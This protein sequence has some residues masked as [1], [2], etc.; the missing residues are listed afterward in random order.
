MKLPNFLVAVLCL[1]SSPAWPECDPVATVFGEVVCLSDISFNEKDKQHLAK[2][3]DPEILKERIKSY[4]IQLLIERIQHIAANKILPKDA[5]EVTEDD[6]QRHIDH[7]EKFRIQ[8]DRNSKEI[9]S[10]IKKLLKTNQYSPRHKEKLENILK[11][12]EGYIQL[13]RKVL[14]GR[15]A[16]NNRMSTEK[17]KLSEIMMEENKIKDHRRMVEQWKMNQALYKQYGGRI[18]IQQA[19]I[20]PIDAY[21]QFLSDIQEKGNLKI[22]KIE[23]DRVI[24]GFEKYINMKHVYSSVDGSKLFDKPHWEKELNNKNHKKYIESLKAIPTLN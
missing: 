1:M 19:E 17:R 20:E 2:N 6:V 10:T 18:N 4:Q 9:V 23:F 11:V 22:L 13:N 14:E 7:I 12:Y 24:D 5:L 16:L 3:L 15:K 8:N 21:K